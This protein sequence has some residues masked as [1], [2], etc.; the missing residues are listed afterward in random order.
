LSSERTACPPRRSRRSTSAHATNVSPP[1][2][3]RPGRLRT[4]GLPADRGPV[5]G[6]RRGPLRQLNETHLLADLRFR[7]FRG[8]RRRWWWHCNRRRG[9]SDNGFGWLPGSARHSSR[10]GHLN[11]WL[12]SRSFDWG[13]CRDR[14]RR[15]SRRRDDY[16]RLGSNWL[17]RGRRRGRD[18]G[19]F[20]MLLAN[21]F[22]EV[23]RGDFI[24]R[25]GRHLGCGNAQFLGLGKNLFVLQ[26][27]LLRNVVNTNGHKFCKP[28]AYVGAKPSWPVPKNQHSS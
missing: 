26:T 1:R 24:Q 11:H 3:F 12:D 18:C 6:F 2:E 5:C 20:R 9:R 28:P 4:L 19:D 27:Q 16:N 15:L 14:R 10:G 13:R 8:W 17:G 23:F 7:R 22:F 21:L 25:T